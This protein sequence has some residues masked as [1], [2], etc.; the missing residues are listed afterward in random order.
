MRKAICIV[1]LTTILAI[2]FSV[3][4]FAA[5]ALYRMLHADQVESFQKAQDALIV[6]Q[7]VQ[8]QKSYFKVKV[9]RV[10]VTLIIFLIKLYIKRV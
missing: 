7:L 3:S 5:D 4:V 6:G 8:K 9:L 10:R 1:C 2:M